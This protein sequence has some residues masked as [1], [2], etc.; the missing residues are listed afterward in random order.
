MKIYKLLIL[1]ILVNQI[2][3]LKAQVDTKDSTKH[4]P[5][6]ANEKSDLAFGE[7][8]I[9]VTVGYGFP[10]IYKALFKA[11]YT[12]NG[13]FY[14]SGTSQPPT[15]N[16]K[17][18]GPM[19]LKADYGL[20][21]LVSVGA[22]IGY[23][24]FTMTETII[25]Q[26]PDPTGTYLISY[27]DVVKYYYTS[28]SAG[29]RINFHFGTGKKLDP[30]AGIAGG[31]SSNKYVESYTSTDPNFI[32]HPSSYT[33]IPIYLSLTAGMRYYFTDNIGMYMEVGIDKWSVIQ[34]G[35][36]VKF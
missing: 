25:D 4:K 13:S 24:N 19:F 30:Y 31:Y 12:N 9:A 11:T 15:V 6:I 33:G 1:C 28:F 27:T 10:N 32:E 23:D 20:T 7:R 5:K 2:N 36:A 21:K 18:I 17:G 14:S 22:S 26:E 8:K 34:G 29:V 3:T 35:L 16:I